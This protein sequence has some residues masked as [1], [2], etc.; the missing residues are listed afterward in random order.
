MIHVVYHVGVPILQAYTAYTEQLWQP[1]TFW[2][3]VVSVEDHQQ[4]KQGQIIHAAAA[5][6]QQDLATFI[7]IMCILKHWYPD[8]LYVQN[9]FCWDSLMSLMP[10]MCAICARQALSLTLHLLKLVRWQATLVNE[11]V[12]SSWPVTCSCD[13]Q[14]RSI[15]VLVYLKLSAHALNLISLSV[16][17]FESSRCIA[18]KCR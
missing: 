2:Q 14:A 8:C 11:Q 9:R 5:A 10:L 7:I 6:K 16:S 12:E 13:M 3:T 4:I 15:C 18:C 1:L 17:Q